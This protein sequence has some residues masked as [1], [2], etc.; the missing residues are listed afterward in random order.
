MGNIKTFYSLQYVRAIA[1]WMVVFFHVFSMFNHVDINGWGKLLFGEGNFGVDIFFV[2]SGFVLPS[3]IEKVNGFNNIKEMLVFLKNRWFRIGPTYIFWLLFFT[4]VFQYS[5]NHIP[6]PTN[7]IIQSFLFITGKGEYPP[8]AVGWSLNF[9]MYFYIILA[10]FYYFKLNRS[11]LLY[12]ALTPIL[13]KVMSTD[14]SYLH[15]IVFSKFM[16]EFL[17]GI[18]IYRYHHLIQLKKYQTVLLTIVTA[19]IF[20]YFYSI[21][22][23]QGINIRMFIASLIVLSF[24]KLES[25]YAFN[26]KYFLFL[27]KISYSTYLCHTPILSFFPLIK[28]SLSAES[29][30]ISSQMIILSLLPI[31]IIV[32]YLSY[33]FIEKPSI[34][35]GKKINF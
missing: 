9:E 1:C 27:G 3:S 19:V 33:Q 21:N 24:I 17:L 25:Y 5:L 20:I 15:K 28:D 13:G 8:L 31:I 4:V 12:L 26:N 29:I 34:R 22:F 10:I 16:W 6:I 14:I 30:A 23:P 32:S 35:L 2:L 18:L 11:L 7:E